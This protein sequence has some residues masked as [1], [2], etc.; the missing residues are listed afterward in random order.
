MTALIR[1]ILAAWQAL[2]GPRQ[3]R[4]ERLDRADLISIRRQYE[5]TAREE[6]FPF[7]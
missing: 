4:L 5:Q 1:G 7:L 6:R 3:W 2:R